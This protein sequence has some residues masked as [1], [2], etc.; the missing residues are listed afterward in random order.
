[1]KLQIIFF[2]I[3]C[4]LF[5][6]S[7]FPEEFEEISLVVG[8]VKTI[9]CLSPT[10]VVISKPEICDVSSVSETEI[11]LSPKAVGVTTF[12]FWD[13]FGEHAF[14]IR[15]VPEDLKEIKKRIDS[16]LGEMGFRKVYTKISE[17]EGKIL[18]LGEVKTSKDKELLDA[19]LGALKVYAIDLIK[20]K[21]RAL[22]EIDVQVL[23]LTEEATKK[24]G[25][26]WPD[27]LTVTETTAPEGMRWDKLWRIS[28][29]T[30]TAFSLTLNL[31]I[32]ER[33]ARV[34]SRPRLVTLSGK[35]AKLLVGGEVPVITTTVGIG[36]TATPTVEY[37]EY[38]I[39]LNIKPTVEEKNRIHLVLNTEVSEVGLP[40]STQHAL[41]YPLSKRSAQTELYV[42]DAQTLYIGGL[43]EQKMSGDLK[44]V[45]WLAEVPI[46]GAF[47]RKKDTKI[48]EDVELFITLTPT[49]VSG[50]EEVIKEAVLR[51]E[52]LPEIISPAYESIPFPLRGYI[53][54]IKKRLLGSV[55]Y[56]DLARKAGLEGVVKLNLHILSDGRLQE[57]LVKESS[58]YRVLDDAACEAAKRISPYPEFPPQTDLKELWIDIP[59]IF[60]QD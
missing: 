37:K 46:L 16:L 41:A 60:R 26:T 21:E 17:I 14:K 49:I 57:V 20:I 8:Q 15:I 27:S 10:K 2:I 30:R 19:I 3:C 31:L 51:P 55:S 28:G 29:W 23:E 52:E 48:G 47:F 44:K 43:I 56:P 34:L 42:E 18:L 53:Y 25:F 33:K 39:S 58:G 1:V 35:E 12:F 13:K 7:A 54:A 32:E 4:L 38:G 36:A 24:L 6:A 11:V 45:P 9:S 50:K 40:V 5:T 59:I 22:V